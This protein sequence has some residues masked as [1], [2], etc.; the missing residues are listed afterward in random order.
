MNSRIFFISFGGCQLRNFVSSGLELFKHCHTGTGGAF[1][2]G[3]PA[4]NVLDLNDG[5]LQLVTG[6]GYLFH[7]Q[8]TIG[9]ILESDSGGAAGFYTYILC[10]CVRQQVVF[11]SFPLINGI[12][13]GLGYRQFNAAAFIGG[14][15]SDG[16]AVGIDDLKDRTGQRGF[17]AGFQLD[18][19]QPA[20]LRNRIFRFGVIGNVRAYRAAF[21]AEI[22]DGRQP[23]INIRVGVT[24]VILKCAV[25]AGFGAQSIENRVSADVCAEGQLYAA[26]LSFNGV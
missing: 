11:R 12:V 24:D 17:G 22:A 20:F 2:E 4:F 21:I 3:A 23:L 19:L 16:N 7:T 8:I 25:L 5:I 1:G 9:I 15:R 14:K 6:I 26:V 18:D 10:L 13:A